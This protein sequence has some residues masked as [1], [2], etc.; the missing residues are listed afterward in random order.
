MNMTPVTI[1]TRGDTQPFV[2]LAVRQCLDTTTW[3]Q[4][5]VELVLL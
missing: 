2:A 1:G 5:Q 3:Q 4:R